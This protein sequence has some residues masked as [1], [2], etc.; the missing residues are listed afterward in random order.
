M[1]SQRL[2]SRA[3]GRSGS[4]D[5]STGVEAI[6]RPGP[7]REHWADA[8][9]ALFYGGGWRTGQIIGATDARAER[10]TDGAIGFQN[11]MATIYR[12]FG[13]DPQATVPDFNGRPQYLLDDATPIRALV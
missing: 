4:S 11:I 5:R 1:R 13:I 9:C 6:S 3:P 12:H 8:G 10:S 2:V 7:G